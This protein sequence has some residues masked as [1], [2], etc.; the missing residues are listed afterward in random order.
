MYV[1]SMQY[2]VSSHPLSERVT[3]P[4]D[5]AF[6]APLAII[7][8]HIFANL[9]QMDLHPNCSSSLCSLSSLYYTT[10]ALA[11]LLSS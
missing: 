4:L 8:A 1:C 3:F 10:R 9:S 5:D 7:L 2:A 11:A 6:C